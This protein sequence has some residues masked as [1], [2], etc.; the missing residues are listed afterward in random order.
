[1][2][3]TDEDEEESLRAEKDA[4][5]QEEAGYSTQEIQQSDSLAADF[6]EQRVMNKLSKASDWS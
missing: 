6:V 1:M 4:R 5:R 3:I 2:N